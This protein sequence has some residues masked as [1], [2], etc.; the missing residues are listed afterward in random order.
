MD[1]VL[2]LLELFVLFVVGTIDGDRVAAAA[3][4]IVCG[5]HCVYV[6]ID[7]GAGVG[8]VGWSVGDPKGK[9]WL[10]TTTAE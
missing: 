10:G 3:A 7:E 6:G 4:V 5:G 9:G 8:A 1:L 2:E